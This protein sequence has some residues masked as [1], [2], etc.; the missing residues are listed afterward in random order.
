MQIRFRSHFRRLFW[1]ITIVAASGPIHGE[2]PNSS[3]LR[4]PPSNS[5]VAMRRLPDPFHA[6]TSAKRSDSNGRSGAPVAVDLSSYLPQ[7]ESF[8]DPAAALYVVPRTDSVIESTIQV[9]SQ[10]SRTVES[11]LRTPVAKPLTPPPAPQRFVDPIESLPSQVNHNWNDPNSLLPAAAEQAAQLV[12]RASTR[13]SRGAIYSARQ[14]LETSLSTLSQALDAHYA[15]TAFS[16]CLRE[17][18]LAMDEAKDFSPDPTAQRMTLDVP[19]T[20]SRHRSHVLSAED[21][22]SLSPI[23]AARKYYAYAQEHLVASLG[24]SPIGAHALFGMG[25]LYM[26]MCE[27]DSDAER[28]YGPRSMMMHQSAL[29]IDGSHYLAANELGVLLARFGRLREAREVFGHSLAIG[30]LPVTWKNLADVH[31]RLGEVELAHQAR[32]EWQRTAQLA[33]SQTP[34]A[35]TTPNGLT[36]HWVDKA[37]FERGLFN[38]GVNSQPTAAPAPVTAP[39]MARRPTPSNHW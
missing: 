16:Q 33:Q 20:V 34:N 26:G 15:T 17:S 39:A 8:T 11:V 24:G 21:A 3:G 14:E 5:R 9:A 32:A 18:W 2:E 10:P 25:K 1:A 13:A 29:L 28:V 7:P 30:A 6:R 23:D 35:F 27:S 4:L 19:L 38:G 37:T 36:V 22:K 31:D 12:R